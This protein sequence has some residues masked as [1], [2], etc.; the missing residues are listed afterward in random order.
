MNRKNIKDRVIENIIVSGTLRGAIN[1]NSFYSPEMKNEN[2]NRR[3]FRNY[4]GKELRKTLN[5]I[6]EKEH[7]SDRNHSETIVRFANKIS[8][9]KKYGAC[10]FNNTLRIGTSQKLINLYWKMSWLLRRGI[11]PPIHCPFDR[12]IIRGLDKSVWN[13]NWTESDSIQD[14]KDLVKAARKKAVGSTIADWE[15]R[16]YGDL[17]IP[18]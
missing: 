9:H 6:L 8:R 1:R 16:K 4:L 5:R 12:I 3:E 2:N 10:L 7:Y 18:E 11:D 14:Y 13:I 17:T 15:L